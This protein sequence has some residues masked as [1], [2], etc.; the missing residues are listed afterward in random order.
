MKWIFIG[1]NTSDPNVNKYLCYIRVAYTESV[2]L[3][4]RVNVEASS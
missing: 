4:A 1:T 2:T 3:A